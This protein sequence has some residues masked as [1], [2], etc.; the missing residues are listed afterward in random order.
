ESAPR[1]QRRRRKAE[2]LRSTG[3]QGYFQ[4]RSP[5][6]ATAASLPALKI[7]A[8]RRMATLRSRTR[9]CREIRARQRRPGRSVGHVRQKDAAVGAGQ[10][11]AGIAQLVLVSP[12]RARRNDVLGT[13]ALV[14]VDEQLFE[15]GLIDVAV[16]DDVRS[17]QPSA[18]TM[19]VSGLTSA[20]NVSC[21]R[22]SPP[23][24]PPLRM[25]RIGQRSADTGPPAATRF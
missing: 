1:Q 6:G 21:A 17:P 3:N 18:G 11:L 7:D 24:Q 19:R 12:E 9:G 15:Q 4:A 2:A 25:S 23:S 13:E 16:A 20:A 22:T 10:K 8:S 5:A 14:E